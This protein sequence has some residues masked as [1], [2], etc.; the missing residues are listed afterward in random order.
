MKKFV[1]GSDRPGR[2][3]VKSRIGKQIAISAGVFEREPATLTVTT[4][5]THAFLLP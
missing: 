1:S 5:F 3:T 4:D 2:A